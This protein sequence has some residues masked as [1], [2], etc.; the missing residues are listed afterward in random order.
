MVQGLLCV[1]GR[2]PS[3]S[4]AALCPSDGALQLTAA[5]PLPLGAAASHAALRVRVVC[6][7]AATRVR[8]LVLQPVPLYGIKSAGSLRVRVQRARLR[9]DPISQ[10]RFAEYALDI[11]LGDERYT[12]WHRF[13]VIEEACAAVMPHPQ[14][15]PTHHSPV[16]Q[17][18]KR[19]PKKMAASVP[20]LNSLLITASATD[21]KV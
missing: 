7:P 11:V 17:V 16:T 12:V 5:A 15:N 10:H 2:F 9:W 3:A 4:V 21:K 19:L 13:H 8:G 14:P 1:G 6:M 20:K 18:K